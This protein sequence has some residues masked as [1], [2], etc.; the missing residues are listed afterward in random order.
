MLEKIIQAVLGKDCELRERMLRSIILMGGFATIAGI[1]EIL[2]VMKI[3]N[4]LLPMLFLLL[5]AMGASF[6]ATF[7]Y[8]K[9]DYAAILLGLVIIVM[10]FPVMFLLSGALEGGASIWLALGILYIFIMFSGKRLAVFLGLT[11]ISYGLTYWIAYK[12][13]EIIVPMASQGT[14]YFD[15]IFSLFIVGIVSGVI[16]KLHMKVY[17][18][19]HQLNLRQKEELEASRD[20]QNVFFANMSHEIR[21]PINA[22]IGM[23]E[24]IMRSAY[25]PEIQ[26]YARE[27]QMASGLLLNQ[28]NDILDLSQMTMERM[29]LVNTNYQTRAL[30]TDLV[31]LIKVQADKK[32][33][34]LILDIDTNI[35]S[36]LQGDEKRLKQ[37]L[38]NLLDNAVKYTEKG[39][40]TLTVVGEVCSTDEV[41]LTIKIADTGIGIRKENLERIYD[42]FN[43]VDEKKNKRIAGS[44]LGLAITK[45]LIDLMQGEIAVDSIYTKGTVF[46]IMIHQKI[47]NTEPIGKL[48]FIYQRK[49]E[50]NKYKPLFEAPEARV[51]I[52]D[53]N[54]MNRMVAGKLLEATKMQVDVASSG[55]ECL[56]MTKKKFYHVILLDYMMPEM[57]GLETLKALHAQEN[58]LCRDSAVIV[59]TGNTQSG[60][61][62]QYQE[63]G[64]DGYVEKPIQGRLLENE[65][66]SFLPYDIVE[67]QEETRLESEDIGRM[68]KMSG[69]KRKK[70]YITTD[71]T[72]DIPS[73]LLEKYDIKL[74]Y[75]YI[76]TPYGRF[77]DTREIDSD[78]LAQ[79]VSLESSTAY[80]DSVTV[81][82]FE[83]FF[84][85][86]L[87]QAEH[88][89]HI[90]LSS[91][92]GR[93]HSIA[94][95]AAKGFDHV[96]VIDSG[97][98]SCGQ[99]LVT[100]YAAKLA[101]EGKTVSEI[102]ELV[103]NMK[104][105]VHTRFIMPSADIFYQNGRSKK[106]AL[107]ACQLLHLHPYGGMI[108]K[109]ATLRGLLA[110]N[111]ESAWR[112]GIVWMFRRKRKIN[113]DIV[114]VTHVGCS[115]K[116]QEW[117]KKEI[118]KQVSFERVIVQKASF[119]SACNVGME[120]IGIAYYIM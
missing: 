102:C 73:S 88:V 89:I 26:E 10:V 32:K 49:E 111:L 60:A 96:H 50:G 41:L 67:Y 101:M 9:Y 58:G 64:F 105:H 85:E 61:R 14:A 42:S 28:V 103:D 117:I 17:E 83:E 44:G 81:E 97:Q 33:L 36:V 15:S 118:A 23:N 74:M 78:S 76:K 3:N 47:V 116:Q 93:S 37:I 59:L 91:K 95:A 11:V 27:I 40:V 115:I 12:H 104:Q 92:A 63:E 35:P 6:I 45:Q 54:R 113:K 43:R 56:E 72:C 108:Q 52:V 82:E 107:K 80:G 48:D 99:G 112:Q 119:T 106:F 21:T 68:Q 65:I 70:I 24:M 94:V 77:A 69:R 114:F 79:Y 87:T 34:D 29:H 2:L 5:L 31:N 25:S 22:I 20:S 39:S 84:A 66:Y 98:I 16:L 109:K 90:S 55:E 120:T 4:I 75:L 57:D 19:E 7:K 38:I 51:L 18:E 71:C 8:R 1:T 13:P 100:L 86:A 46:T 62:Q 30:F 53:D 110:G